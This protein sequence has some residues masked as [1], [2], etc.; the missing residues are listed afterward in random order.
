MEV[1]QNAFRRKERMDVVKKRKK[2]CYKEKIERMLQGKE[3]KDVT[4]K[5]KKKMEK[6]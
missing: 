2:G 6:W 3:R 4:R 1:K 5:R